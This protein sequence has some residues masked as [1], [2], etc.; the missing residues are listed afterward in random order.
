[1]NQEARLLADRHSAGAIS[2]ASPTGAIGGKLFYIIKKH[3]RARAEAT[4]E[5][6]DAAL[7]GAVGGKAIYII[8]KDERGRA[9]AA[10]AR[11]LLYLRVFLFV[12]FF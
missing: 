5:R 10:A 7:L 12:P 4:V 9:E 3:E 1:M 11:D 2:I 8:K 6:E